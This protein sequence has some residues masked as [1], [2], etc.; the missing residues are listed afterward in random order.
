MEYRDKLLISR[1]SNIMR[2]HRGKIIFWHYYDWTRLSVQMWILCEQMWILSQGKFDYALIQPNLLCSARSTEK[3]WERG[4]TLAE[5]REKGTEVGSPDAEVEVAADQESMVEEKLQ[6][7]RPRGR[8]ACGGG[9]GASLPRARRG[10]GRRRRGS[11]ARC[12]EAGGYSTGKIGSD[13]PESPAEQ[14]SKG[15]GV[16]GR[17]K[18]PRGL[19]SRGK[20][21]EPGG[22]T[23]CHTSPRMAN[24][25]M[26]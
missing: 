8:S 7:L 20:G 21:R 23:C 10:S 9:G 12:P 17:G 3:V 14:A 24:P 5:A 6:R 2:T 15:A 11:S 16:A 26:E 4:E 22:E 13:G 19:C 18:F 1:W 25:P